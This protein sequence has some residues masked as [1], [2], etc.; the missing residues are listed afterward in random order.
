MLMRSGLV[1]RL[2]GVLEHPDPLVLENHLVVLRV[3][4]NGVE[5]H[6]GRMTDPVV[7]VEAS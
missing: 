1:A 5:A 6:S 7:P 4:G 2:V 3:A